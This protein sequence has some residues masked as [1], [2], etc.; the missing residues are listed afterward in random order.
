MA[1]EGIQ[2]SLDEF[3]EQGKGDVGSSS[4]SNDHCSTSTIMEMVLA[5]YYRGLIDQVSM[6]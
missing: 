1:L 3:L 6:L 2:R 4:R 5:A